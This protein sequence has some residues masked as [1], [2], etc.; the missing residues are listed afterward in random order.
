V[1]VYQRERLAP[2]PVL[3]DAERATY[4]AYGLGRG[5]V[6]RVWGPKTWWGYARRVARG[7]SPQRPRE[8]TLQLGGD[9][10]IGRDGVVA[11]AF[12][13]EDPDDRPSID[14]I[15]HVLRAL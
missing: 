15:V 8:D 12:R 13:S 5:S 11:M 3:I 9:F 2:I 14:S 6:W 10:V 7:Q 4:R 1:A